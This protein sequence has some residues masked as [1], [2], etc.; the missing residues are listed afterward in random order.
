MKK[1]SIMFRLVILLV[2]C[3]AIITLLEVFNLHPEFSVG[4]FHS[5]WTGV[6]HMRFE[7]RTMTVPT[8]GGKKVRLKDYGLGPVRI[9]IDA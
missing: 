3:G 4:R 2:V 1:K 9:T 7:A 6:R 5:I 8:S